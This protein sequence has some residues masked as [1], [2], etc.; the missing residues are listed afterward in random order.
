VIVLE[1]L[2][3]VGVQD[4]NPDALN[5]WLDR[6]LGKAVQPVAHEESEEKPRLI[7]DF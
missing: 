4:K 5:K 3:N 1:T 6:A 7:I 2:F